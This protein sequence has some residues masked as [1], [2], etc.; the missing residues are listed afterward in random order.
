M[1]REYFLYLLM[2]ELM[3]LE[4]AERDDVYRYYIEYL[5]DRG[6]S[7][8]GM[9]PPDMKS[10][11][12]IAA[13][14]L[15][16]KTSGNAEEAEAGGR[17]AAGTAY[18]TES[19]PAEG[20]TWQTA[21][22]GPAGPGAYVISDPFSRL[23]ISLGMGNLVIS[24][25][26][27]DRPVLTCPVSR[28]G[29]EIDYKII[30]SVENGIL[31]LRDR[32][33]HAW[34]FKSKRF[35]MGPITLELPLDFELAEGQLNLQMGSTRLENVSGGR[36]DVS[37]SMGSLAINGGHV[38]HLTADLS[39]G[40]ITLKGPR[41]DGSDC[42]VQMGSLKGEA[43]LLG[44]HRFSC[45]LGSVSLSLDQPRERTEVS[46]KVSLGS[47]SINGQRQNQTNVVVPTPDARLFI[48]VSGGGV[49]LN[50]TR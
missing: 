12:A 43:V 13:D 33:R 28:E 11:A 21:G 8:G 22:G 34:T 25:G 46:A 41:L 50:F 2:N 15:R 40:S 5:E 30:W 37:Q 14:I 17:Q 47:F 6:V 48:D 29:L 1:T 32:F 42:S 4:P 24:Q 19:G 36:L 23:D 16:G 45:A 27:V 7:A 49:T 18:G 35:S 44:E 31:H 26:P 3:S 20:T 10:P 9:I 38:G 39:M